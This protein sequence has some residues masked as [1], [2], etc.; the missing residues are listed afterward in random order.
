MV[1]DNADDLKLIR[2]VDPKMEKPPHDFYITNF[3][4]LSK[5]DKD[6][7]EGLND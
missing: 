2:G 3:Y 1:F 6:G 7:V 4:H 5:R